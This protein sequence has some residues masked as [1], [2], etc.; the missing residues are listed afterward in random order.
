MDFFGT[1]FGDLNAVGFRVFNVG[2]NLPPHPMAMPSINI[3]IN[4]HLTAHPTD[5]FSTLNY[6]RSGLVTRLE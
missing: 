4:P 5:V 6:V 2:E 1:L 3:E